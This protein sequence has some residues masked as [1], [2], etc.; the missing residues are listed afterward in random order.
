[1]TRKNH[2]CSRTVLRVS[3]SSVR[4]IFSSVAAVVIASFFFSTPVFASDAD[5]KVYSEKEATTVITQQLLKAP[6]SFEIAVKSDNAYLLRDLYRHYIR[7]DTGKGT[8]LMGDYLVEENLLSY[9]SFSDFWFEKN[10]RIQISFNHQCPKDF[11]SLE[12]KLNRS[13]GKILNSLHLEGKSEKQK[14]VKIYRYVTK[15]VK[16]DYSLT[17]FLAC[18]ALEEG[19]ATCQGF[20]TLFYRLCREAGLSCR[21]A[22]G[23]VGKKSHTW[24]VVKLNGKWYECDSSWDAGVPQKH[25]EYFLSGEETFRKYHSVPKAA[26]GEGN[27]LVEKKSGVDHKVGRLKTRLSSK[28]KGKLTVWADAA[29]ANQYFVQIQTKNQ[30]INYNK[31]SHIVNA[32]FKSLRSGSCKVT[33]K[34][35]KITGNKVHS[36]RTVTST[37][38]IR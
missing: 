11:G 15:H 16:Y 26:N 27:L 12:Q 35:V 32:T 9:Y 8:R 10:H 22:I 20:S 33:V 25:W 1:M 38:R 30:K 18:E 34:A 7:Q 28:K 2:S 6:K 19:N 21:I 29:H 3:V 4:Q 13:I 24:N 17:N 36:A 31:R 23:K 14:F 5:M 37:V